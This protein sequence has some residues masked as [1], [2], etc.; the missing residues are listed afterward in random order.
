MVDVAGA[1]V[2]AVL[3]RAPSSGGKTRLFAELGEPPDPALLEALL[4]DTIDGACTPPARTVVAVTP[5]S[6]CDQVRR[7][8]GGEV[9][10]LPQPDG[11]LGERMRGTMADLF[12]RGATAVVLI[13][14]D[15]PEITPSPVAAA[16]RL[17]SQDVDALV[18]GPAL[19]G[20][21]YLV[22]ANR[23]PDVFRATEWGS[24]QA[25]DQT[26]REAERRG[27]HVH[28][29][30]ALRDVDT[31]DDLRRLSHR[32]APRRTAAWLRAR[33]AAD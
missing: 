5:G 3:T 14:S 31:I 21:Y 18:L 24:A 7:I 26:R 15:L 2:L 30:E 13:G 9:Q 10:V 17:L 11:D 16:L 23:P 25:L 8:V 33:A 12:E 20:G 28:L 29:V 1:C 27:F 22:A 6:A 32:S 4:L 19:D